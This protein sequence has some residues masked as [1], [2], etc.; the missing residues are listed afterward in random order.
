MAMGTG[1]SRSFVVLFCVLLLFFFHNVHG[2]R[3]SHGDP[4]LVRTGTQSQGTTQEL[5]P[6]TCRDPVP[7]YNT[8]TQSEYV[9]RHNMG[10]VKG[11]DKKYAKSMQKVR[12]IIQKK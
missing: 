7:G 10:P 8:G 6:G 11:Y 9:P 2:S 12:F 3:G 1:A 4:I 5:S